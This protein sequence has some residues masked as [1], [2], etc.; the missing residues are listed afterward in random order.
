M[1]HYTECGLQNIWLANGFSKV[2]TRHGTGI[3][4]HDVEGL[5]RLIGKAI[6]RKPKMTGGEFRFL[7]KEMGLSQGAIAGLV[8]TTEQ[9]VSLWERRGAIPKSADR[10]V[11]LIY[12]EHIGNNAK[13][14]ELVDRL[15]QQDEQE[16]REKLTFREQAGNW[17]EAA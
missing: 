16:A 14:R 7:R 9:T 3:A 10:L 15:A 5:H 4:I 11:R 6:A 17:K 13:V 8:G 2:K 1:Y 12:L